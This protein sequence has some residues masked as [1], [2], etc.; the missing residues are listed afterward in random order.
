M[1]KNGL[2]QVSLIFWASSPKIRLLFEECIS[3]L[4]SEEP[5]F[6]T[7]E[8]LGFTVRYVSGEKELIKLMEELVNDDQPRRVV[9]VSDGLL[10]KKNG[11]GYLPNQLT[12][13]IRKLFSTTP[14]HLCGIVALVNG[15]PHRTSDIDAVVDARN[16]EPQ[17]LRKFIIQVADGLWLKSPI[18]NPHV[19]GRDDAILVQLVRS[20]EELKECFELRYKVYNALGYLEEA[21]SSNTSQTEID[22]FDSQSIHFSAKDFASN[23]VVGTMRLVMRMPRFRRNSIV[24][25]P[26]NLRNTHNKWTYEIANRAGAIFSKKLSEQYFLPFPI[27]ANSDF[28][29]KWPEFL[30]NYNQKYGGEVSRI[31]VLPQYRGLGISRLLLRAAFATAVDLRKKYLLLECIPVHAVMYEKYGFKRLEGHHCRAQELDQVAVGM[32]VS[33]ED[34]PYNQAVSLA[35]RDIEMIRRGRRDSSMLFGSKFLCLCR[36]NQCWRSANYRFQ[37]EKI[38]PLRDIHQGAVPLSNVC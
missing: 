12:A 34:T 29:E 11:N 30:H 21:V 7:N 13:H 10:G 23:K 32:R 36:I 5:V 25:I 20:P 8:L 18:H 35:K 19:Q 24:G 22:S 27:L 33:F 4:K 26:Y 28:G 9:L 31:V 6:D 15:E 1:S 17:M 3:H 37:G 38:C 14:N 2:F 16:L